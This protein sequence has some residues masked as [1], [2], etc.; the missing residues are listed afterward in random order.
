MQVDQSTEQLF[1]YCSSSPLSQKLFF[2][3]VVEEFSSRTVFQNKK[4]DFVPFPYFVQL[5]YM[6]VILQKFSRSRISYQ[7]T[8]NVDLI[9][10][11]SIV[12]N[13]LFLN[14][15]N[16]K[17]L[18]GHS[19]LS[20]IYDSKAPLGKFSLKVILIFDVTLRRVDEHRCLLNH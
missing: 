19:M 10:K 7:K 13:L 20:K 18:F 8:Q 12:F 3:D 16:C 4:A 2:K 11:S 17:Q 14:G 6:R 5:N 9:Y 1:H 15:L